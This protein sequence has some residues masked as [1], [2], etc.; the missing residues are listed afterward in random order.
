MARKGRETSSLGIYH[1]ILRGNS[2]LFL[3]EN[4]YKEFLLLLKKYFYGDNRIYAYSLDKNKIHLV[5]FTENTVSS[6]L[7]PLCTSYAR[8]INRTHNKTGKLFYDRFLSIPIESFPRLA[9]AVRYTAKKPSHITSL[10]EYKKQADICSVDSLSEK[11]SIKSVTAGGIV[12]PSDDD[13]VSMTDDEVKQLICTLFAPKPTDGEE[14]MNYLSEAVKVSN[15]SMARLARIFEIK[16]IY[17][18]SAAAADKTGSVKKAG[19]QR[20]KP[21]AKKEK[22]ASEKQPEESREP[23]KEEKPR[24]K[25]ELSV[26]LL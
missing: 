20:K 25:Q 8:Y 4:D 23:A 26:W 16:P 2:E 15:L 3:S 12:Y 13:Y 11:I 1:I 21:A 17:K 14:F 18:K 19:A 6:V 22:K 5:I 10:A 24:Q 9:L 7:K